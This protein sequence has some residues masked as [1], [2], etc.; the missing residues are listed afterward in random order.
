[1]RSCSLI[2]QLIAPPHNDAVY[3]HV[4]NVNRVRVRSPQSVGKGHHRIADKLKL[5]LESGAV[6]RQFLPGGALA[7]VLL[8][9]RRQRAVRI[10]TLKVI[11]PEFCGAYSKS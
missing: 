5:I 8:V 4:I 7:R 11:L 10:A 6:L 3:R 2:S 1:M 9:V